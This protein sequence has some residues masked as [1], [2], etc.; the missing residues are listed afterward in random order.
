[1]AQPI[2]PDLLDHA[3]ESRNDLCA[4]LRQSPLQ[5]HRIR[6]SEHGEFHGNLQILHKSFDLLILLDLRFFFPVASNNLLVKLG[7]L[8]DGEHV[9]ANKRR[10]RLITNRRRKPSTFNAAPFP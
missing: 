7:V 2:L 10:M 9:R 4:L 8:I 5:H 1:M 3:V 6:R